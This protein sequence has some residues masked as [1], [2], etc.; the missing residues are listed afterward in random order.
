MLFN[1]SHRKTHRRWCGQSRI[2]RTT[3]IVQ[4]LLFLTVSFVVCGLLKASDAGAS[5]LSMNG[6]KVLDIHTDPNPGAA[7]VPEQPNGKPKRYGYTYTTLP[8]YFLQD[9]PQTKAQTF[10][11]MKTN[12]GLVQRPYDSD[13]SLPNNGQGMTPWQRFEN[14]ITSLNHAAKRKRDG[15]EDG[16]HVQYKLLFLGRHGNGYHNIAERHYGNEAWDCHFSALDGDPDDIMVWSDAH[17]TKEGRRQATEVHD[18]WKA[19]IKEEKMSLPQAYVVSPLDRTLQTAEITFQGIVDKFRPTVME[20]L[21]EGT[22]IHT[23]DRRSTVSY[24]RDRYPEYITTADPLLTETDEYWD[25]ELREPDDVLTARL[26]KLLDQV[27]Q[28][29][30]FRE[31]ETISFTS[32]SGAIGAM[33]RVLAHRPF[34]LGTGAVIPV[35]VKMERVELEK[36]H[37][38]KAEGG[39]HANVDD[40]A[41]DDIVQ[42]EADEDEHEDTLAGTMSVDKSK[43]GKIPAC[44]ADMDLQT[45]GQ[46]RWGMGLKDFLTGVE[47]GTIQPEEVALR[48]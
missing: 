44:P 40:D 42:D 24:V 35:F 6:Q 36:R 31:A 13:E 45:V 11:F 30:A 5:L 48:H 27:M 21:R 43:W 26:G 2:C 28:S 25:A 23:C 12:F 16:G 4:L 20:R 22:G 9:D 38:G 18:F 3:V 19:Q 7:E 1:S 15:S 37:G 10:D 39:K 32:H 47:N 14:H 41:H 17:L 29:E 33:L 34:S 8:G 46:K